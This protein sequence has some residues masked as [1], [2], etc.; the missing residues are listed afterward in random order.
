MYSKN[1]KT[2]MKEMEGNTNRWK[3]IQYSW[4]G[5]INII[6][7]IIPHKVIYKLNSVSIKIHCSQR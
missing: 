7:M 3:D 4:I 5:R 1:F 6:K 2:S